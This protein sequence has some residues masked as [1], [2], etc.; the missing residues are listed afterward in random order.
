MPL[1]NTPERAIAGSA[2]AARV[3]PA[4]ALLFG[5]LMSL[6]AWWLLREREQQ[7]AAQD[8]EAQMQATIQ[9]VREQLTAYEVLLRSGS[10]M[11]GTVDTPTPQLWRR[12]AQGLDLTRRF[13][14][15]TGLGFAP[16]VDSG[17]LQALQLE[18][19]HQG[20]T[21]FSI[22]PTGLR[23]LYAPILFLE[24]ATPENQRVV[25]YD[26]FSEPA[27]QGA[28]QAALE[29][30]LARLSAPVQLQQES[31]RSQIPGLLLYVPVYAG[32]YAPTNVAERRSAMRGWVYTPFRA[33][34]FFDVVLEQGRPAHRLR[35]SDVTDPT[36]PILLA[37]SSGFPDEATP[38]HWQ[39]RQVLDVHGRQWLMEAVSNYAVTGGDGS[40]ASTV[41]LLA[42]LLCSILLFYAVWLLARMRERAHV[43][44]VRMSD[45]SRRSEQ[46][47][48]RAMQ[49]SPI[50][51]ALL[52]ADGTIVEVNPT[53]V[54]ILAQ[55]ASALVGTTL[56]SHFAEHGD[57]IADDTVR[58]MRRIVRRLRRADGGVRHARL[59]FA[60][61][62]GNDDGDA[63]RLVQVEDI[64]EQ[65]Q[66]EARI[67]SL[68]RTLESRVAERTR[69][70]RAANEEM[71]AFAYSVS[72][73]LRAP[74]RAINGFSHMLQ[75]RHGEQLDEDARGY[76]GRIQ[77]A[78]KR[79]DELIDAL[80]SLAT[81][82]RGALERE[83]LD[84]SAMAEQV[85]ANLRLADP[86]R[87]VLVEIQPGLVADGDRALVA[88]VL[89]NLIGNAW[90][91][92]SERSPARIEVGQDADDQFFVRDNGDG[93]DPA[94][95]G[96][97]FRPFQRLHSQSQFSGH[98]IGLTTVKR[99]VERHGG[100]I[101]AHSTPGQ[102]ATFRFS[103]GKRGNGAPE[104]QS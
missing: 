26:M 23:P 18:Q 3:L 43:L 39:H 5:V 90:K 67:R 46:R 76:L 45:A 38:D 29:T 70:L 69:E 11:F 49:Y 74:L 61:L 17:G 88:N 86:D 94:F 81:V 98:G 52:S 34:A 85:I 27:R 14:A 80:L 40:R 28:M 56:G 41:A 42:G 25:G 37:S 6:S 102:G 1:S 96:K 103:L 60:E 33:Q 50:G 22:R 82:G 31:G 95:A 59:V 12:Y 73:D 91:F 97:L 20:R 62:P 19:H 7:L 104:E 32:Q 44:A 8:Y 63:A 16:L 21:L 24:P 68:N 71:E 65:L 75:Q 78:A 93:F 10:A 13:P 9:K 36:H 55:P 51:T 77:S 87:D 83:Q 89:E 99:I 47:F 72:H 48:R 4:V 92:S 30:G 53:L 66:A 84:M 58:G 79:M 35:L 2:L 101:S 57:G 15:L 100:G 64:T 54:R